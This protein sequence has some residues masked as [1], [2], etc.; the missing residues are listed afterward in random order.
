MTGR[1]AAMSID[2]TPV[3]EADM[4]RIESEERLHDEWRRRTVRVVASASHDAA[5]CRMLLSILGLDADIVQAARAQ[6]KPRRGSGK[7]HAQAVA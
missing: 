4:E 7:R 3:S 6:K 1:I 2:G 5:D